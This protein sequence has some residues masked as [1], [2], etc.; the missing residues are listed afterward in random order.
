LGPEFVRPELSGR[1]GSWARVELLPGGSAFDTLR[2]PVFEALRVLMG[3]VPGPLIACANIAI[4]CF[5]PICRPAGR[6]ALRASIGAD[7]SPCEAI[8]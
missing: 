4:C 3:I 5:A 2:R 8:A 1:R 6:D 7:V